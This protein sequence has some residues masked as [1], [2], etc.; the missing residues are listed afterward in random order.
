LAETIAKLT[1]PIMS[2]QGFAG[3]AIVT[4]W[5]AIVGEHI[6]ARSIPEKV[7]HS[8][9]KNAGGTLRLRVASGGVAIELQH[10]EPLVLDRI[11][12]YFGYAAIARLQFVQR[13]LPVKTTTRPPA[14]RPL[15]PDEERALADSLAGIDD[16]ELRRAVEGLARAV[17]GRETDA[18]RGDPFGGN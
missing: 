10:L 14:P 1:A 9:E 2:R 18:D 4:E 8:R 17:V 11:N 16:A 12:T 7:I 6:A 3:G 5:P 13:P 15:T